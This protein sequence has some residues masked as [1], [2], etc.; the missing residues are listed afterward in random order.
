MLQHTIPIDGMTGDS[1]V[2]VVRHTLAGLRGVMHAQVALGSA[3]VTY[4]DDLVGPHA[5][6]EAIARAGFLP[7]SG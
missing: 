6:H 3:R 2:E 4:D 7:G 1:S 5:F